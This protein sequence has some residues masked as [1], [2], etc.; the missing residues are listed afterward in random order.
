MQ[1]A[2]ASV[3]KDE[4]LADLSNVFCISK[5]LHI[6]EHALF[7]QREEILA[8]EAAN[9]EPSG[10]NCHLIDSH[11]VEA[12]KEQEFKLSKKLWETR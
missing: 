1:Q 9:C 5:L 4:G 3:R 2:A 11:L 7:K 12:L 6:R 8:A 10:T